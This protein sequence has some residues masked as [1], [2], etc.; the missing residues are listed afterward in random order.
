MRKVSVSGANFEE[1]YPAEFA[2]YVVV[3]RYEQ[4][5]EALMFSK[6]NVPS[7]RLMFSAIRN[8]YCLLMLTSGIL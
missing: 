4:D 1:K 8:R 7:I 6:A 3:N 2:P 5:I